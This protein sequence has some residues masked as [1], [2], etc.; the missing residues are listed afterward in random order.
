MPLLQL[1]QQISNA[2]DMNS[3]WKIETIAEQPTHVLHH[4]QAFDVRPIGVGLWPL[5]GPRFRILVGLLDRSERIKRTPQVLAFDPISRSAR[6]ID[7][8]IYALGPDT[9]FTESMADRF[10]GNHLMR[11]AQAVDVTS[12]VLE[13]IAYQC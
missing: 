7:G 6:S 11:A 3:I 1:V 10:R 12:D 8:L 4:W 9:E 2:Q 5:P 13:L